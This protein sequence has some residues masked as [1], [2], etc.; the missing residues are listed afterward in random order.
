MKPNLKNVFKAFSLELPIYAVLMG[1]YAFFVFYFLGGWLF[2]LFRTD[3]KLYAVVALGLIV[4]QG[5]LLEIFA[6]GL[7][8]LI[9]GRKEK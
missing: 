3:R 8:S 5:F 6:R 4:G 9:N 2:H 7:L 1:I